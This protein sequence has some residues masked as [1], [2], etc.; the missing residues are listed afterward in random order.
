MKGAI[1]LGSE[2][3]EIRVWRRRENLRLL[4]GP[5]ADIKLEPVAPPSA[6]LCHVELRVESQAQGEER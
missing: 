1:V 4:L 5:R 3:M 6:D 2:G